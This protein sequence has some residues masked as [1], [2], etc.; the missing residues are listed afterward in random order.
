MRTSTTRRIARFAALAVAAAGIAGS[1]TLGPVSPAS[2]ATGPAPAVAVAAIPQ[3]AVQHPVQM[4]PKSKS[5]RHR[6]GPH[7]Q[8]RNNA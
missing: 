6:M 4:K 8:I 2:A 7:H 1:A 3:L 5:P